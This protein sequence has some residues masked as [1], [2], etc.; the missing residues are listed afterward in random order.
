VASLTERDAVLRA[1]L[2]KAES[3]RLRSE[4]TAVRRAARDSRRIGRAV[5]GRLAEGVERRRRATER[6]GAW[7]YWG[8]ATR[9]LKSVL[10]VAADPDC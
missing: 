10:V 9:D 5:S 1:R 8:P 4:T 2:S 3:R 7:P 6:L